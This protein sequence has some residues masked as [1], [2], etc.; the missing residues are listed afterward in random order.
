[1][2][3]EGVAAGEAFF[4]EHALAGLVGRFDDFG[5]AGVGAV[6]GQH[7]HIDAV[8]GAQAAGDGFGTHA[9]GADE[10]PL[11][12]PGQGFE[13]VGMVEDVEVVAVRVDQH[14]VEPV[15]A[16]AA[17]ACL[18]AGAGV[19]GGKVEARTSSFE[20]LPDFGAKQPAVALG[21]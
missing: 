18:D 20:N 3:F 6:V 11:A 15:A 21:Q 13:A 9:D 1:M 5:L 7:Q 8:D 12:Q 2:V 16:Q 14:D 19:A 4:N 17:Q 10:P